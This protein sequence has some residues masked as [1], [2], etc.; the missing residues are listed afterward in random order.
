[1]CG[2]VRER[3]SER[4]SLKGTVDLFSIQHCVVGATVEFHPKA[5]K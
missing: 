5:T 1:M 4:E 3:E 2:C